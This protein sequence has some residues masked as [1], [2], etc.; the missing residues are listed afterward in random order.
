MQEKEEKLKDKKEQVQ[1][2]QV[3]LS[4]VYLKVVVVCLVL[5]RET[6]VLN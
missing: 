2:V 3:L 4:L 5:D 1:R 6:T